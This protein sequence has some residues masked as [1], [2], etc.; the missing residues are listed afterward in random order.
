MIYCANAGDSRTVILRGDGKTDDMSKDH[1]PE[2]KTESDR[3]EAAGGYVNAGRVNGNLNL[4]RALGDFEYKS[5]KTRKPD[6]QLIISKPD[7]DVKERKTDDK[8]IL[9]GCD[10]I[11]DQFTN[12][13]LCTKIDKIL[14][15]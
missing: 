3:I 1:K 8:F 6:E 15:D 10:G 5:D 2:D 7:V 13:E 9:M 4:T 12:Q 14:Q 11:F